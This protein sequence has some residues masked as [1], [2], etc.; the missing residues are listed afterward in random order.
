M[1]ANPLTINAHPKDGYSHLLE[2]LDPHDEP[3]SEE[4]EPAPAPKHT[5]MVKR[6]SGRSDIN[7]VGIP[8][9]GF[10]GFLIDGFT[11]LINARWSVIILFFCALYVVS[12]LASIVPCDVTESAVMNSLKSIVPSLLV[13]NMLKR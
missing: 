2:S 4:R 12:W 3:V 1:S 11:T 5:R 7:H 10:L 8:P 13:S 9:R 6:S